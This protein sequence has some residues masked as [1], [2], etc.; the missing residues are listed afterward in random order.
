MSFAFF[1]KKRK[2]K[3]GEGVGEAGERTVE[4]ANIGGRTLKHIELKIF[5][6]VV[7]CIAST[8]AINK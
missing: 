7:I 6:H 2:K 8:S 5:L 3:G 4:E 1:K